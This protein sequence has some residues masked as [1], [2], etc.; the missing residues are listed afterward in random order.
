MKILFICKKRMQYNPYDGK[1]Y[2]LFNSATFVS[3]YLNNL[4]HTESKVIQVND[5]NDIDREVTDYNPRLVII[6]ALWVTAAKFLE[7]FKFKRH[8]RRQWICRLHS[9][10]SFLSYESAALELLNGYTE[11]PQKI[12]SVAPN[13]EEVAKDMEL[14]GLKLVFLP[15]IYN[16]PI[17]KPNRIDIGCFG[18]I[19]PFKNILTQAIASIKFANENGLNLNFHINSNRTEQKGDS[20]L[21]N[22]EQLFKSQT[23][24]KLV[25]HPWL[26][27]EEFDL[28]VREMDLGLQVSFTETFNIVIADF[29]K[30][31]IPV[32]VSRHINWVPREFQVEN[33]NSTSEIVEKM[34]RVYKI[35]KQN[36]QTLKE[37][38]IEAEKL[39]SA[40]VQEIQN[41]P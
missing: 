18:S 41:A 17:Y 7:L 32:V 19:R 31:R 40:F 11:L 13:N 33:E 10:W 29:I 23:N 4:P 1:A 3:N 20:V 27:H 28:L 37:Y 38:N 21:K 2:G 5:S 26:T 16:P 8:Q 15:N 12:F 25:K 35:E 24:H 6:E 9:Q 22:L 34:N 30:N 39:W 14:L 36:L